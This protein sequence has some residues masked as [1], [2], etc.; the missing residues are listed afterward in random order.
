MT[1][2]VTEPTY[3]FQVLHWLKRAMNQALKRSLYPSPLMDVPPELADAKVIKDLK[4]GF[5]AYRA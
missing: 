3:R 1:P 4:D 5:L 2:K